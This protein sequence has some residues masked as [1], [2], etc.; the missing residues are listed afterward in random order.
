MD[1]LR[2]SGNGPACLFPGVLP[3]H[4]RYTLFPYTTLFRSQAEPLLSDELGLQEGLERLGSV[5]RAQD[6]L[7]LVLLWL[8]PAGLQTFL[9][10]LALSRVVQVHV[11][12]TDSAAVG[13]AQ[14]PEDVPQ[15]HLRLRSEE[16]RVGTG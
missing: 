8:G 16:R 15:Q 11:L 10:P 9:Q 13:V 5:Q 4:P 3:L 12:H 2:N 14:Q 7:L 1:E 6:A